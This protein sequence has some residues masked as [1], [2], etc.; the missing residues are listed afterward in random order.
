MAFAQIEDLSGSC[1]LIV[2]PDTYKD[3]ELQLKS[4]GPLLITG[5][6]EVSEDGSTAKILVESVGRLEDQL[7]QAKN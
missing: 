6:V 2:F 3:Y 5:T 7:S 4:M 1:E